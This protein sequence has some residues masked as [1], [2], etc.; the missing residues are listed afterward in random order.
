MIDP[1]SPAIVSP[2]ISLT[3]GR[4]AAL[5]QENRRSLNIAFAIVSAAIFA[6]AGKLSDFWVMVTI[7]AKI[8]ATVE[9]SV[10]AIASVI[11]LTSSHQEVGSTAMIDPHPSL[12]VSPSRA[13]YARRLATLI[14]KRDAAVRVCRTVM[15]MSIV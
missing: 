11:Y 1:D 12:V 15:P 6:G 10:V 4:S 3:A 2:A 9:V 8:V 7:S 13:L 5:M 14:L